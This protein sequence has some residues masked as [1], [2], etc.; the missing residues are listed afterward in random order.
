MSVDDSTSEELPVTPTAI[1][2]NGVSLDHFISLALAQ[3]PDLVTLRQSEEVSRGALGVA[4]TYPFNPSVQVQV[5]PYQDA[6]V[7]NLTAT[8]HYVLL[9]QTI[10][11]AHQQQFREQ[12]A[13]GALNSTRWN[14]HQAELQVLAQTERLYFTA[15]YL[16]GVMDLI[17]AGDRNNRQMLRIVEK[18]LEAG[19]ATAADAAIVRVDEESTRQQLQLASANY[20][21][22]VRDLARHLG[23]SSEQ[24]PSVDSNLE[25]IRWRLAGSGIDLSVAARGFDSQ[26]VESD[27]RSMV[28]SKASSRPDVMAAR[29]DIDVARANLC[30]ASASK[31]PDLQIG[32]YYQTADNSTIYV[33]LRG[34]IDL[35]I[36]N[37]GEPLERQRAAEHSQRFVTWRQAQRRAELEAVAAFDRYQTALTAISAKSDNSGTD[38]T[39]ALDGLE[40]QFVAGEVDIVRVVQA[41]TSLL[42]NQRVRLDLLN[43]VAQSAAALTGA[44]GIPV[45]DILQ[46]QD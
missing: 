39:E 45:A 1:S 2:S 32:P 38:L 24:M 12:G 6:R 43:E 40:K 14:I 35:P 34:Q 18:Q 21:S 5:T 42:Q 37:N 44:T 41:R 8:N 31:T 22:A 3:N 19:Q 46:I 17:S 30:L 28:I 36:I 4:R 7:G 9:M 29:S 20:Q 25:S 26:G 11:L 16:H 15:L 10:Q 13:A 23:V 33:G 27:A